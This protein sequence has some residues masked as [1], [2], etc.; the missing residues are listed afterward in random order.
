[1]QLLEFCDV[2]SLEAVYAAVFSAASALIPLTILTT[3]LFQ[4]VQGLAYLHLERH[5][6]H[7]D[8]KPANVLLKSGG[9]THTHIYIYIT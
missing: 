6:L 1:M 5:T 4:I 8:L 2:G 9:N 7:R 3:I